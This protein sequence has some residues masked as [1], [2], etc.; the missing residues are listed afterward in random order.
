MSD[1]INGPD[2]TTKKK[3]TPLIEHLKKHPL[4]SIALAISTA[5][6]TQLFSGA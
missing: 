2:E 6:T 5:G 3:V 4:V 1:G